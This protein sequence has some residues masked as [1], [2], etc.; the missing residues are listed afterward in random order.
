MNEMNLPEKQLRSWQPRRPSAALRSRIFGGSTATHLARA[1][2]LSLRCLAPVTACFLLAMAALNQG[3]T[4]SRVSAQPGVVFGMIGSNQLALLSGRFA[5]E[6]QA[7][8]ADENRA[9][10]V[11]FEWTNRSGSTS[12]TPFTPITRTN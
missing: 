7:S 1:V 5:V 9:L 3:G 12:S 4:L 8:V 10:P 11:T 6:N 2:M